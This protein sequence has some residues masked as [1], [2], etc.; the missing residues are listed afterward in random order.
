[1]KKSYLILACLLFFLFG[2]T[3]QR[4]GDFMAYGNDNGLPAALYYQV[5]QSS[6]GYLWIG[7]ST[8]LVRFDGKRYKTFFSDYA[9]SNS[10]IDN[11]I[12][13]FAEDNHQNLFIAGFMQGLTVYNLR[14]GRFT[15]YPRLPGAKKDGYGIN[16]LLKDREGQIWVASS[17]G[18][19]KLDSATGRFEFFVPDASRPSDGSLRE[20]NHVTGIVEDPADPQVLWLSC[21]DGLYSFDKKTKAFRKFIYKDAGN[22]GYPYAFLCIEAERDNTIWLGTWFRGLVSFDKSTKQFTSHSFKPDRNIG[23]H[24]LVL[25]IKKTSDTTLY[26]ASGNAGLLLF[27]TVTGEMRSLLTTQQLPEGS[28]GINIQRISMTPTAGIF[29]GGNYYIYQ[30]HKT[31]DRF[32]Q[33]FYF[34][35]DA[36]ISV[37]QV[38]YDAQ[39][40]GYWMVCGNSGK[41]SVFFFNADLTQHKTFASSASINGDFEDICTDGKNRVWAVASKDGL[42][43]L[44]EKSGL[45][46]KANIFPGS[47]TLSHQVKYIESDGQGNLWMLTRNKVYYHDILKNTNEEF[48]LGINDKPLTNLSFCAGTR[49]DVWVASD[50]GLFHCVYPGR[51]IFHIVAGNKKNRGIAKPGIKSMTVDKYGNAWLGFESDGVQVVDGKD[52]MVVSS[53]NLDGG[54]PSMQINYMTTDTSGRIWAGTQAGLALFDPKVKVWQLFNRNDGIKRDYIDRPI[55]ATTN[56]MFFLNI[57]NGFSWFNADVYRAAYKQPP[58]LHITYLSVNGFV[59]KSGLLPDYMKQ[60]SLPYN[61]KE[62]TI[63]YAAIDWLYPSRTKYFYRVDGIHP[64]NGW[65]SNP[66][67]AITL[68]GLNPGKYILHVYA[69][70]GDGIRSNEMEFAVII[71]PAFWQRWWFI[72]L[73]MAF[74]IGI[75]YSI[76]RYRIS[77]L[78]K[79]QSMRNMISRNLHDDIGASLSNIHILNELTRR[80][81][82]D[83]EKAKDYISTA[84]EDIQ[85]ISESLSDIV[86]NINPRY[87]DIGNLFVRMKRYA[88]DMLDGKNITS[89]L[90]FP[91]DS[92]KMFMPMDQRRDFY[93][94]FK[95]AINNLAKYSSAT[96][97]E[98]KVWSGDHAI[99]LRVSDNGKGFDTDHGH[100]GN[101]IQNMKQ[102]ADKWKAGLKVES[103][104]GKGTVISLDMKI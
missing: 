76:Y 28:S 71:H 29:A 1:L 40:E 69:V 36:D 33:S 89:Q 10:L 39:R 19:A 59:Y 5:F 55:I 77:Q 90:S 11:I 7:S 88:A 99:H 44:K 66:G 3:Q 14:T 17:R 31:F 87:D 73:C 85:R 42:F 22:D 46:E 45:F 101:G 49:R 74:L 63:E 65:T 21:F 24:Y 100:L 18:L 98:V 58:I 38:V 62:I 15:R 78:K 34:K 8:G 53:H 41:D 75:A 54:L 61:T 97:A 20:A 50:I 13:D 84:G 96:D 94:I 67:A 48:D 25:D 52:N 60:L 27:N 95:E 32:A 9:D 92:E 81:I 47:D 103:K 82:G 30:R 86:W 70:N 43:Q 51:K 79:L 68:T 6:D 93:L 72:G 35:K 80:N 104:M 102:R 56:G 83:P 26:L 37:N 57:E 64:A 4:V 12:V 16:R 23:L 91:S 2:K